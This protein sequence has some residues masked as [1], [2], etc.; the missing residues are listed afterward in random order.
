[1]SPGQHCTAASRLAFSPASTAF[2]LGPVTMHVPAALTYHSS[3][4]FCNNQEVC[5]QVAITD[6]EHVT[7]AQ[8]IEILFGCKAVPA[9][10]SAHAAVPNNHWQLHRACLVHV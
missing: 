3:K 1:M 6:S 4:C 9:A 5:L 2:G 10:W 7:K 8:A